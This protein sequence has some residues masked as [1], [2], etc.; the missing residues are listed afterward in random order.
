[1]SERDVTLFANEAF[2][3]AF[4]DRDMEA[5]DGVWAS[6]ASV[7]CIHPGWDAIQERKGN[8]ES[9][10]SILSNPGSPDI[11]C[12]AADVIMWSE[13]AAVVCFEQIGESYLMATNIYIHEDGHWRIVHHQAGPTSA[14]P[15]DDEISTDPMN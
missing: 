11:R 7:C 13:V 5:M 4:A 1:M 2:Y 10:R 14:V 15:S 6:N 8:L 12:R 9:W 3:R